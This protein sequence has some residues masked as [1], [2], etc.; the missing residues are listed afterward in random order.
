MVAGHSSRPRNPLDIS[1][2]GLDTR[3][4]SKFHCSASLKGELFLGGSL[5][6]RHGLGPTGHTTGARSTLHAPSFV[7]SPIGLAGKLPG[8]AFGFDSLCSAAPTS[9][10]VSCCLKLCQ[11]SAA[12]RLILCAQRTQCVLHFRISQRENVFFP[13]SLIRGAKK[14]GFA[15]A[16]VI[17]GKPKELPKERDAVSPLAKGEDRAEKKTSFAQV[18]L[19]PAQAW[20]FDQGGMKVGRPTTTESVSKHLAWEQATFL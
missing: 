18:C 14:A 10:K 19:L 17:L 9:P 4:R 11:E 13:F 1:A 8:S 3:I 15:P 6:E 7:P 5:R 16:T 12:L 2:A 20:L